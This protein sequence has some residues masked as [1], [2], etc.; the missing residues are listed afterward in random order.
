M[1]LIA[2]VPGHCLRFALGRGQRS[3]P[4]ESKD[5]S[6]SDSS[7][8]E[9]LTTAMSPFCFQ[10]SFL[11]LFFNLNVFLYPATLKR[12]GYYVIP[13]VQKF[14]FEYPS[15]RPSVHPSALHFSPLS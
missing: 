6:D 14:A 8:L 9:R 3:R 11:L 7:T 15:V 10:C 5:I 1:V 12:A 4:F 13:S 2:P